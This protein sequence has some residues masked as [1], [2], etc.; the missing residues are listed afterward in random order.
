MPVTLKNKWT[1]D[2]CKVSWSFSGGAAK[3]AMSDVVVVPMF[4]PKVSG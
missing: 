1:R 3:A 2:I 4:D